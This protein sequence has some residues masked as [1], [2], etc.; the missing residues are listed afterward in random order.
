MLLYVNRYYLTTT[1]GL[2][3]RRDG[4]D[5]LTLLNIIADFH[6]ILHVAT[7]INETGCNKNASLR[8]K[9]NNYCSGARGSIIPGTS[10][11]SAMET[12]PTSCGIPSRIT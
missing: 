8:E 3:S 2:S 1:A 11:Q 6:E 12:V 4:Y 9:T 7:T 5:V 10:C